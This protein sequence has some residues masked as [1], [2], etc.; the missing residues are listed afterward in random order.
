MEA[1]Q[2]VRRLA[3]LTYKEILSGEK[4]QARGFSPGPR[5]ARLETIREDRQ[6][7]GLYGAPDERRDLQAGQVH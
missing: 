2:A 3:D 6:Q 1:I 5:P 7:T 4:R